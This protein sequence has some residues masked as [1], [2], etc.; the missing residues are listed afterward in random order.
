MSNGDVISKEDH[1]EG[2]VSSKQE[3]WKVKGQWTFVQ[4]YKFV[5]YLQLRIAVDL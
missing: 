4:K 5:L 3:G 1:T 2:N